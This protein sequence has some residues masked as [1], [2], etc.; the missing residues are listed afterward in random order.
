MY[1]LGKQI[2]DLAKDLWPINRSLTGSG[3]RE[4]L[5]HIKKI[6]PNLNIHEVA[7]G[8][9]VFDWVVP[10]EWKVKNAYIVTP[11]GKKI[12]DFKNNNLH[13]I[14]LLTYIELLRWRVNL[15]TV[16]Y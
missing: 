7:S 8:T 14:T 6:I 13:V 15:D 9:K 10:S 3:V 5:N 12:C 2:H 1:N 11:E 4:T 16:V